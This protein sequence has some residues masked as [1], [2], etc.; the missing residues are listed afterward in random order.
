MG[1]AAHR[2][3]HV[4]RE[5]LLLQEAADNP[6]ATDMASITDQLPESPAAEKKPAL[7]KANLQYK[8]PSQTK[9]T[10]YINHGPRTE[11]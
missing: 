7:A 2:R 1:G 3:I 4:V 8:R 11:P 9:C 5:E 10:Y 6:V